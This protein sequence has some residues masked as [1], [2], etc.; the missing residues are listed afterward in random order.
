MGGFFYLMLLSLL[1]DRLFVLLGLWGLLAFVIARWVLS[2]DSAFMLV[3]KFG[4]WVILVNFVL[5]GAAI[6]RLS[7]E[8]W[9]RWAPGKPEIWGLI[10]VLTTGILWQVHEQRGFKILA[11]EVL[12]LGTSMDMHFERE[13][14][15]PVRATDVQG[16]F[17][18]LQSVLDKRPLFFPFVVSIVHDV[19]GYRATNPFY[20]NLGLSFVFLGL[21]YLLG[22]KIGGNQW[23]GVL[24]VLLFAGLPLM[25]QQAAGGGFELLN[26]VMLAV[27]LWLACRYAEKPDDLSAEALGLGAVLLAQT[28]YE[29]AVFILPVAALLIWGWMKVGR[30]ILPWSI[31]L[32]PVFLVPY[33]L[34]NRQFDSNAS[35]WE[36]A[37]QGGGATE[38]FALHYLPDNLGHALAFFFD[39]S[40]Y[41]ANSILF[42]IM[43]LVAL[44][45]FGIWIT[46]IFRDRINH[47][48]MDVV[49]ATMGLGLL[50]VNGLFMIYFWGQFD[51]PVIRRLSLPLH[52]LMLLAIWVVIARWIRWRHIWTVTSGAALLALFIQGLPMMAKRAYE[53]DYTPGVEMAWRAEFLHRFPARDYLFIDQDS[54]FWITQ[55]IPATPIK[56]A[57]KRKEGLIYHLRNHS[58]SAMY[59]FQRFRVDDQTG[60]LLL[61]P[62][63]DL[64]AGFELEPFWEKRIATLLI[65][66]ISRITEIHDNGEIALATEYAEPST[67]PN[68]T[69]EQLQKAKQLYL[70]NWI[71]QLP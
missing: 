22:S 21:V 68:R 2:G 36:L 8:T 44:P 16:P 61:D 7:K 71:K 29:S 11:D 45:L 26:L 42:A 53:K 37:G 65:G 70:E 64:G 51:H 1:K 35:L 32:T 30:M 39:T 17:Q 69:E 19:T 27:V 55:Q 24:G 58:F 52:F 43:G 38:P 57:Q 18:V 23:G 10:L 4:Y 31:W 41:Q 25:A 46:R 63:D 67:G 54:F 59:V 20:V 49:V 66:R 6:W 62:N 48:P 14:T 33:V 9:A 47:T 28:R 56:Q 13:A 60:S 50:A 12:L 5:F 15:Y 34:Q 3:A 40:G